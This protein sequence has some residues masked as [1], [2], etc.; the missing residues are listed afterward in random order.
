MTIYL[1]L[2]YYYVHLIEPVTVVEP[3]GV[4]YF[5]VGTTTKSISCD[6][7]G[8]GGGDGGGGECRINLV[9]CYYYVHLIEPVTVVESYGIQHFDIG[10]NKK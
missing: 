9:L 8:G 2:F 1:V 10:T 7:G 4:Q 3:Y 5:N 6:G